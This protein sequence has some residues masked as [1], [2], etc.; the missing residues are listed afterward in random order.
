MRGKLNAGTSRS[1]LTPSTPLEITSGLPLPSSAPVRVSS[2]FL[3]DVRV[4]DELRE[5]VVIERA[6][7]RAIGSRGGRAQ[8]VGVGD[9]AAHDREALRLERRGRLVRARE[10]RDRVVCREQLADDVRADEAG[11]AGD[12]RRSCQS[13]LMSVAVVIARDVS[14]CNHSAAIMAAMS[15]WEP[16]ASGRLQDAAMTLFRERGYDDTTVADIA[17]RA[18]LTERT[19]LPLLRRQARGA[20]RRL[21]DP[22]RG[23]RRSARHGAAAGDGRGRHGALTRL[24]H[25]SRRA[26]TSTGSRAAATP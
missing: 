25:S 8:H 21:R 6:V 15:R 3:L 9:V 26:R 16:N 20:V 5:V 24:P 7:N 10:R 22:R 14:L 17:A 23:A 4:L 12:E 1:V 19:F 18:G 2:A 11:R 13:L